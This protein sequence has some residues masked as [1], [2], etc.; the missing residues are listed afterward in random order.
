M[1]TFTCNDIDGLVLD[2]KEIETMP[3]SVIEDILMAGAE[4][5]KEAHAKA[6]AEKFN[7]HTQKLLG[8]PGIVR[9]GKR[10]VYVYP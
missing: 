7:E 4:V 5:V 8:S 6:I 9:A 3:E 1:A 10:K 2:L